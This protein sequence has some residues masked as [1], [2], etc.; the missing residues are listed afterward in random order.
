MDRVTVDV[1]VGINNP[2]VNYDIHATFMKH[3]PRGTIAGSLSHIT[4]DVQ[5]CFVPGSETVTLEKLVVKDIG[6]LKAKI[7]GLGSVLNFI[8]SHVC[9]DSNTFELLPIYGI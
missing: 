8:V 3:G 5:L 6:S 7:T 4:C 2:L 1:E 9:I